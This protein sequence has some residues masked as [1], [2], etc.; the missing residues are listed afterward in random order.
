MIVFGI[1][2]VITGAIMWFA[3]ASAAPAL[4]QWMAF[5]H[6]VAFIVTGCMFFVHIYTGVFHPLMTD[7]WNAI[8]RGKVSTEYAKTHHGKWYEEITSGREEK[9]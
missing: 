3:K 6:D 8:T 4:L 5:V 2:F 7:S 9:A 1:I